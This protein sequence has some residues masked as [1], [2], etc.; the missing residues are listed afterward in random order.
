MKTPASP[1]ESPALTTPPARPAPPAHLTSRMPLRVRFCETDL[2]GIVHHANYLLYFEA[3]RIDW[4]HRRGV[5][6]VEWAKRGFHLPV[7]EARLRYRKAAR[8]D[9]ALIVETTC[10][11]VTR[12]TVRFTYS[13][14]RDGEVLCEGETRLA[15]VGPTL[16]LMRLPEDVLEVF[17][18]P[19]TTQR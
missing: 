2:M 12:V 3:G 19:E 18:R 17:N 13:L 6:Y 16:A 4:M 14:L 1:P 5:E 11:E 9:E 15:C 8:F 7:V 10:A